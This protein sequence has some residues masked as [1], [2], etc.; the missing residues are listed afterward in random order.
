MLSECQHTFCAECFEEYFRSLIEDQL[1]DHKLQCP[2]YG[3][4]TKP[5]QEEVESIISSDCHKKYTK[6][7]TN[8]KVAMDK[9]LLFCSK[10]GCETVLDM[11]EAEKKG[12]KCITCKQKTCKSC[13]EPFHGNNDCGKASQQNYEGWVGGLIIHKCPKC[14]CQ[15]E[16]DSGCPMMECAICSYAWC[17]SCGFSTNSRAHFFIA[18]FC[19]FY[20]EVVVSRFSFAQKFFASLFGIILSPLL[21]LFFSL[22]L[23]GHVFILMDCCKGRVKICYIISMLFLVIICLA[24]TLVFAAIIFSISV[25]PFYLLMTIFFLVVSFRWCFQSK[26]VKLTEAQKQKIEENSK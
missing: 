2:E 23:G 18:V 17:W 19:Q 6:F 22:Y 16:K 26:K 1:K 14:G 15:V 13:K 5:S 24:L 7:Q 3:C 12:I 8:R 21:L 9:N 10:M 4:S 20:N 25:G 11:R